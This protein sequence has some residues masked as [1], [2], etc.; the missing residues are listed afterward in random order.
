ML[1]WHQA[2]SF[3]FIAKAMLNNSSKNSNFKKQPLAGS[4]QPTSPASRPTTA[5]GG[6]ASRPTTARG[7]LQNNK[8]WKVVDGTKSFL[9]VN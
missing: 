2:N 9:S 3:P 7:C 6:P 1:T 4:L 8:K 5:R